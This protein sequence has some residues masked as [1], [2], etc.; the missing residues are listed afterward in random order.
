MFRGASQD[1][2]AVGGQLSIDDFSLVIEG[3][4]DGDL[5]GTLSATPSVDLNGDLVDDLLAGA[6]AADSLLGNID[7]NAGR[8]YAAYGSGQRLID[9]DGG[10]VLLESGES[11][12]FTDIVNFSVTGS[13]DFL[14]KPPTGRG[15]D[16]HLHPR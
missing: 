2:L 4:F 1:V 13:G 6:A 15:G 14:V 12:S 10:R 7:E 3:E 8:I 11:L 9:I 16:P 5:F